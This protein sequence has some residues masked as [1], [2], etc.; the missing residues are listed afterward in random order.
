MR[1]RLLTLAA[2]LAA[3]AFLQ[4]AQLAADTST[5]ADE[6][7]IGV[8][9]Y[10]RLEVVDAQLSPLV[11]AMET[12]LPEVDVQLEV[13]DYDTLEAG[14]RSN[15]YTVVITDPYHYLQLRDSDKLAQA[16]ATIK[17]YSPEESVG[18]LGGVIVTA[19]ARDD[20]NCLVDL[21]GRTVAIGDR[22]SAAGFALPLDELRRAGLDRSE[23]RWLELGSGPDA[24]EAVIR[25]DADAAFLRSALIESLI[26]QGKLDPWDLRV[27]NQQ[28]LSGF[29]FAVSTRLLPEWPLVYLGG[30]DKQLMLRMLGVAL[31]RPGRVEVTT[32]GAIEGVKPPA[33]YDVVEDLLRGLALPPFDNP[34]EITI[35]DI[36]NS[37]RIGVSVVLVFAL[38]ILGLVI[39]LAER[40]RTP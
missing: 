27:L 25:G 3:F 1:R 38:V 2:L 40:C 39:A 23:L 24:V 21:R 13:L 9:A 19:A 22:R 29:P 17:R 6:I 18:S 26:D 36:W 34:Q 10:D 7:R 28:A 15:S 20:I 31:L 12:Q 33:D 14:V 16:F 30:A 4:P 5:P 8:L 35:A 32:L 11:A 37:H